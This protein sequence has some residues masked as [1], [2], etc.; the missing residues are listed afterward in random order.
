MAAEKVQV[1]R[2][3]TSTQDIEMAKSEHVQASQQVAEP[4]ICPE[5]T[6]AK[7]A[8]NSTHGAGKALAMVVA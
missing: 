2:H 8:K 6:L 4:G 5:P 1:Y 3:D 7:S